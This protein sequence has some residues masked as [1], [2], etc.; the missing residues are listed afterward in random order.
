MKIRIISIVLIAIA[1]YASIVGHDFL[2]EWDDHWVVINKYTE[3]GLSM[4]NGVSYSQYP[5]ACN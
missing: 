2:Y 5:M 1:V 4:S 3:A